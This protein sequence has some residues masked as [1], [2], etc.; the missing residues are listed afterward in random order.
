M[1]SL[2]S[3]FSIFASPFFGLNPS[4]QF[5]LFQK[6]RR[7]A[8]G[9]SE[10]WLLTSGRR[11]ALRLVRNPRARRYILRVDSQGIPQV[12]IPRG[13]SQIEAK[14]F[15]Q[16]H[17]AWLEKQLLRQAQAAK[18]AQP[19]RIG[20][21]IRFRGRA[22]ILEA[23]GSSE[24]PAVKFESEIVRI[25]EG[26]LDL[27]EPVERHLWRLA[28]V[29]FPPRV[30]ELAALHGLPAKRVTVRNQRSRW[31]SCSR[32]GTI[33]LNWRLIQTPEFVRDYIILHELVHLRQMNHSA[34]FWREVA[35]LCPDFESAESW[36]KRHSREFGL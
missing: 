35:R 6:A 10:D 30:F 7:N 18:L 3:A 21:E 4:V 31:G 5:E 11:L 36:L 33:S 17:S 16:K 29:E 23:A 8:P 14:R 24:S 32:R 15:V 12:T 27:R 25:P 13:G 26:T 1:G 22:L 28:A 2:F 34:R 19:W 9:G 20:T